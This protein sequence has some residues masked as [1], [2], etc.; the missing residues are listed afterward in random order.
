MAGSI[1]RVK[2]SD[3]TGLAS[4]ATVQTARSSG[5]ST[6]DVDTVSGIPTNFIGTMG[7]PHTFTDPVTSETI[8]VI[9]E[10]SAVDFAG[11][12]DGSDLEIDTIAPGQSDAGSEIGDIII[13]RPTTQWADNLAEVLEKSHNDDGTLKVADNGTIDDE[14]GNEQIQFGTVASAVNHLKILNAA[15]GDPAEIQGAGGD[16]NVDVKISGKGDGEVEIVRQKP[17][18]VLNSAYTLNTTDWENEVVRASVSGTL[19]WVRVV[20]ESKSTINDTDTDILT[21]DL[22]A[23]GIDSAYGAYPVGYSDNGNSIAMIDFNGVSGVLKVT[24]FTAE[25]SAGDVLD[26]TFVTQIATWA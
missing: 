6:I 9:S 13:I 1:N 8:T 5:S 26:L 4:V 10:A 11:H 15:T 7:T 21:L 20:V 14:N 19:L 3:G 16:S 17:P 12:V 23:L 2:G 18:T 24:D 22:A 25:I